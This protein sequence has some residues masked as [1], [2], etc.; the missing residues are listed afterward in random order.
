MHKICLVV[1]PQFDLV[2][3]PFSDKTNLEVSSFKLSNINVSDFKIPNF[4]ISKLQFSN[5]EISKVK[6]ELSFHL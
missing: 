6:N 3:W 5:I 4:Q 2:E 1:P